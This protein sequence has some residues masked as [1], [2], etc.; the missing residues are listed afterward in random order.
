MERV[1]EALTFQHVWSV[2]IMI[3]KWSIISLSLALLYYGAYT[4][5]KR[6]RV[7]SGNAAEKWL[8]PILVALILLLINYLLEVFDTSEV[9]YL[10]ALF[11]A[12]LCIE[13]IIG[14]VALL[15]VPIVST[16]IYRSQYKQYV[17]GKVDEAAIK[18]LLSPR[19]FGILALLIC[20][21]IHFVYYVLLAMAGGA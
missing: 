3:A 2:E 19:S 18:K 20:A 21:V 5:Y 12:G 8:S 17:E 13:G 10:Y 9:L 16:L 15:I 4:D 14:F 11:Y 1:I 7:G 6:F